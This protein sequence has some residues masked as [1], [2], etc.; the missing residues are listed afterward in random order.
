MILFGFV[1]SELHLGSDIA[2]KLGLHLLL[3]SLHFKSGKYRGVTFIYNLQILKTAA[4]H[5]N[6]H[7]KK[8]F[9]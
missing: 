2:V 4:L 6:L 3:K 7:V 8:S 9:F 1:G 5:M